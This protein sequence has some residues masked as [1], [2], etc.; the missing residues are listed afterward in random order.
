M[1][2]S[3]NTLVDAP[4]S[5]L[6]NPFTLIWNTLSEMSGNTVRAKRLSALAKLSDA[7]LARLGTSKRDLFDH[8]YCS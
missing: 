6:P 3:L 2:Q 1:S 8:V 5:S 7:E 4:A